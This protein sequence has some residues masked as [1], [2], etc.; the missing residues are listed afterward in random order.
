MHPEFVGPTESQEE[1][2]SLVPSP[3]NMKMI[4]M[5]KNIIEGKWKL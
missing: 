2:G 1:R 4:F 3:V 5:C